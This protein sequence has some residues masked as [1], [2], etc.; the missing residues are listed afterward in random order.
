MFKL[1]GLVDSVGDLLTE[2][3]TIVT[4]REGKRK[5]E[6]INLPCAFD[7]EASSFY[8][9]NKKQALLYCW[10]IG[11][12]GRVY[13]GRN[14]DEFKDAIAQIAK[15]YNL[16]ESRRLPVYVHNLAYD[17]QW[18][19]KHLE[20]DSIFARDER[21]IM[22]GL[23]LDGIEFRCSYFLTSTS[24]EVAGKNLTK[25]K[26]EKCV[27]DL[28]YDLVRTP[29]TPLSDTEK[30]YCINDVLVVM[31]LIQEEIENYGSVTKIP[32]TNTGKVRQYCRSVCLSDDNAGRSYRRYIHSLNIGGKEEY[33]LLKRAFQGGF[34]HANYR[35]VGSVHKKVQSYDFTSSY[36]TVMISEQY[37]CT[38][39]V[40]RTDLTEEEI[41]KG[42]RLSIFNAKFKNIREKENVPDN[43]LSSGKCFNM[44]KPFLNNGR[45][46]SAD[47]LVITITNVDLEI[48]DMC[49]DYDSIEIGLGYTYGKS[50]L[51]KALIEC[52]LHFYEKK[53]T[54][55]DVEGSEAEYQLFKGMLNSTY[56]MSVT[57]IINDEI[58][59]SEGKWGRQMP[60]PEEQI[61]DYNHSRNRFLFYPW[62]VFITA[63]ARKNL[64]TGIM[65]CGQD[66]IY[67]DTDSVKITNA[68]D[69]K[70]Y[71]ERYNNEIT[72]K[73]QTCLK[74]YG[75]DPERIKPKTIK[76]KEKPLGVWD[77]DGLYDEFKTLGAK[78]YLVRVG[79]TYK[80]TIAG[81][82][83][84]L[85]SKYIGEQDIPF[86][87]FNDQMEVDEEHSGRLISTYLDEAY[88]G[89]VADYRGVCYNYKEESGIHM[90]KSSYNLTM[91]PEYIALVLGSYIGEDARN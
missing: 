30:Q 36:P 42:T 15:F 68:A 73:L 64:W 2:D 11:I 88:E 33:D 4:K 83:K 26:V 57:D 3:Y 74:T 81:V 60:D 86:E 38:S 22:K 59:Y 76:G 39:G 46:I 77:D 53:T 84:K 37:P 25:Y 13:I 56:G 27:G 65:E 7:T 85:T 67:A 80:C 66:Y 70:D 87:F 69:H 17:F 47:E 72:E 35:R 79:D 19:R 10:Q 61:D 41:R 89:K 75:I 49:Y 50:Y 24:L 82:N 90:E 6:Y 40:R 71:F 5:V 21:K 78:R 8:N 16:S 28:D 1:W 43:Y 31:A 18:I 9:G 34:T 12:N 54:L 32:L 23:T 14:W 20:W 44:R 63:Y 91:T 58:T 55:K 62:G 51:P 45:V 52:V 48:I 29:K